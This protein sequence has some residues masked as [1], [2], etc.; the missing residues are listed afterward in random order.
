M[1]TYGRRPAYLRETEVRTYGRRPAYLRETI[2]A[3]S[4]SA[5]STYAFETLK[6]TVQQ[7]PHTVSCGGHTASGQKGDT[8]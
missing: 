5:T 4:L 1:R 3:R 2:F 7:T 8:P 6:K